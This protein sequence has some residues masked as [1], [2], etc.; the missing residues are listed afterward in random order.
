MV[1]TPFY[2]TPSLSL[3]VYTPFPMQVSKGAVAWLW[4]C[5]CWLHRLSCYPER[6]ENPHSWTMVPLHLCLLFLKDLINCLSQFPQLLGL[7]I[8]LFAAY[9]LIL[10]ELASLC[11]R[12]VEMYVYCF[13]LLWKGSPPNPVIL[14]NSVVL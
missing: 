5:L 14:Q 2:W 7:Q 10:W 9:T 6:V 1:W 11:S 12:D 3:A 13:L 8:L 4:G